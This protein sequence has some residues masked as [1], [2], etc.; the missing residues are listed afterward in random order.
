M[1]T[2]ATFQVPPMFSRASD[3]TSSLYLKRPVAPVRLIVAG[4]E[5]HSKMPPLVFILTDTSWNAIY[6]SVQPRQRLRNGR[7]TPSPSS[8][9]MFSNSRPMTTLLSS[10]HIYTWPK[11]GNAIHAL[12]TPS[13]TLPELPKL[14]TLRNRPSLPRKRVLRLHHQR[15]ALGVSLPDSC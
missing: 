5:A 3:P 1:R 11:A 10:A 12:K 13:R 6:S 15:P 7:W 9:T 14:P 2:S 8:E 4:S